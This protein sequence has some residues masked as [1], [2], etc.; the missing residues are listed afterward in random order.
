[1]NRIEFQNKLVDKITKEKGI[2][3]KSLS[4]GAGLSSL[5]LHCSRSNGTRLCSDTIVR[6]M[7]F[8]GVKLACFQDYDFGDYEVLAMIRKKE[9][10]DE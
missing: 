10:D 9:V 3:I 8:G 4:E 7:R 1:M 5:T 2:T 6:V